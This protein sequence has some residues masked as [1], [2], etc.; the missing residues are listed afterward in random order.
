MLN[1]H[2]YENLTNLSSEYFS[3]SNH[4]NFLEISFKDNP[5]HNFLILNKKDFIKY[6][7][8]NNLINKK[9]T[10]AHGCIEPDECYLNLTN[11]II[12]IIEKKYQNINGSVCEKI[13]TP[14]FK[15]WH[16]SQK[17]PDFKIVYIYCLNKWFRDNCPRELEYL[18]V[19]NIPYFWGDGR[20]YKKQ[21]I[22]FMLKQLV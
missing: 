22:Q 1:W 15:I 16:F 8:E 2:N 9:I 3:I 4:N 11:K 6:F 19:N 13:T 7:H 20:T 21:V 5:S 12:F 14:P 17:F 10:N 18:R